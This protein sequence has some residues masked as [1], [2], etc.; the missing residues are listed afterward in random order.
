[1]AAFCVDDSC[2]LRAAKA[3][4]V[5]SAA[6]A[7]QLHSENVGVLCHGFSALEAAIAVDEEKARAQSLEPPAIG[8]AVSLTLCARVPTH[9]RPSL[10][11][12]VAGEGVGGGRDGRSALL[13]PLPRSP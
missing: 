10:S 9:Q 11:R 12:I 6:T 3:G 7:V 13:H 5:A 2:K 1:M 4:A 8:A